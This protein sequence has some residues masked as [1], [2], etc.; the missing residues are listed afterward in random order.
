MQ[1]QT[2]F[3]LTGV[4]HGHLHRVT[5]TRGRIDTTDSP[6]DEQ[7]VARNMQS[8][9]TNK[10]KEKNLR[11]VGY[12]QTFRLVFKN[13]RSMWDMDIIAVLTTKRTEYMHSVGT[14]QNF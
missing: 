11:Q 4:P 3:H 6:D 1:G 12:L 2:E 8:I 9:E 10:Y 5:Y 13:C 14:M 7:M